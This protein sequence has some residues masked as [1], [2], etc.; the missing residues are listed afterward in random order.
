MTDEEKKNEIIKEFRKILLD[1]EKY[2]LAQVRQKTDTIMVDNLK[3]EF[4]KVVKS[5]ENK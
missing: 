2:N 3:D 1:S 4:E 5:H